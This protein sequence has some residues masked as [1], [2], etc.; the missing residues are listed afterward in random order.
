LAAFARIFLR[1]WACATKQVRFLK[2]SISFL[3]NLISL[4]LAAFFL[5]T[6]ILAQTPIV[7]TSATK[8]VQVAQSIADIA[9]PAKPS[10]RE[11][12][13]PAG[14]TLEIE[15]AYNVISSNVR[16]YDFLSFRVLIPVKVDG[17]TLIEKD[18]L[19]TGRVVEAK[20]GGRWGKSGK[21]AWIMLDVVAVDLSRVPV[22]PN[23]ELPGGD[24]RISGISHGG[25]VAA[26][27]AIMSAIFFPLAP[28]AIIGGAFK[29]GED[30]ILPQGKRFVV[31]VQKETVV[32]VPSNND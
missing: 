31:Y 5:Q 1:H 25:E 9:V 30:A 18:A 13:I 6:T 23:Q 12:K 11:L 16:K 4:I 29:R 7:E 28:V 3:K 14:T 2:G 22:Q 27:A 17:V 24:S 15:V 8:T 19:V 10:R 20:R 32:S 21:L 26:K